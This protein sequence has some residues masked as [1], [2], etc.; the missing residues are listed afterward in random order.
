MTIRDVTQAKIEE[1]IREVAMVARIA[2]GFTFDAFAALVDYMRPVRR[3]ETT[4]RTC[5]SNFQTA[6]EAGVTALAEW[7]VKH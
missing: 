3:E 6:V 5:R 1:D 2:A 4:L 7:A